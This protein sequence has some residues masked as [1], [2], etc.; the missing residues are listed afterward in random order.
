MS[1]VVSSGR[2][3]MSALGSSSTSGSGSVWRPKVWQNQPYS[4]AARC[5]TSPSRL[6]PEG[7]I[8]RRRLV[9]SRPSSFHSTAS[10]W[11]SRLTCRLCFSSPVNGTRR[12]M[13]VPSVESGSGRPPDATTPRP[14]QRPSEEHPR[15]VEQANR[16]E[17]GVLHCRSLG[18]P[19]SRVVRRWYS[20]RTLR[21]PECPRWK[22]T[23]FVKYAQDRTRRG[24]R[25]RKTVEYP[26]LIPRRATSQPVKSRHVDIIDQE[27]SHSLPSDSRQTDRRWGPRWRQRP[28]PRHSHSPV[29]LQLPPGLPRRRLPR[30]R[31][32]RRP[33]PARPARPAARFPPGWRTL[34][35][36]PGCR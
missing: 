11:R 10:R 9:S 31:R 18:L 25:R 12:A 30:R 4:T 2:A 29:P 19:L 32:P 27:N 36:Q 1:W 14:H 3:R 16:V 23:I 34:A 8:A 13:I 15:A 21:Q 28:P 17:R 22:R 33:Q 6:V 35:S 20:T 24:V 5:L 7:V 26:E